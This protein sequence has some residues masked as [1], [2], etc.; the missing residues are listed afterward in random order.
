MTSSFKNPLIKLTDVHLS[1]GAGA[2]RVHILKGINLVINK[3]KSV[4]LIGPS[5]AGKSTLLMVLSGLEKADRGKINVANHDL[6]KLDEDG[7]A[8]F[9]GNHIGIVFQSFQL[10]PNM[11]AL[12]NVAVPL[13]LTGYKKAFRQAEEE[14]KAVGLGE[15]FH[16]YPSALSGGEQQ[17]VAIAR[18]LVAK[19]DLLIADEPTGNLDEK[20][21]NDISNLLFSLQEQRGMTLLLVTHDIGLAKKCN[22]TIEIKNGRII[23]NADTTRQG[24]KTMTTLLS[25]SDIAKPF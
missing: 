21:G 23:K 24:R 11:T 6:T 17:R 14:L 13:E 20:T 19:P 2:A 3:G 15:R 4:S 22:E 16:H 9:R 1:L 12:E 7:L 10:L 25:L 5:G 18:A 8:G